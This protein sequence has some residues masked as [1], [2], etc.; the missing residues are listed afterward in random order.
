LT[1][2]AAKSEC[3][4]EEEVSVKIKVSDWNNGQGPRSEELRNRGTVCESRS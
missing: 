2:A 3:G 1:L 4:R